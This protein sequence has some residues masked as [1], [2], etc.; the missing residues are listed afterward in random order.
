ME[1]NQTKKVKMDRVLASVSLSIV[2]LS[3]LALAIYSK[4]SIA[5]AEKIL[6]WSTSIFSAP[7]MLFGGRSKFCVSRTG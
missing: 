5:F 7:V 4:E 1:N 2:F 6:Y 3:V